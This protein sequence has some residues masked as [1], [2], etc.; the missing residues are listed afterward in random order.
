[1]GDFRNDLS[2]SES[3]ESAPAS[4]KAH[5][6]CKVDETFLVAVCGRRPKKQNRQL[7]CRFPI[8]C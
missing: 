1:M 4:P 8:I 3:R 6:A 2:G 5:E 7:S